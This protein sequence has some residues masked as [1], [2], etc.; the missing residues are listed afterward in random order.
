M[1]TATHDTYQLAGIDPRERGF[2]RPVDLMPEDRQYRARLRYEASHITTELAPS[3]D[4]ALQLLITVLQG[5][6]YRQLKT[7]ISFRQGAYLGSGE[8]WTE[9]PDPPPVQRGLLAAIRT[10][11]KRDTL[12]A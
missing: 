2:S 10:W 7:Q 5:Q 11:F 3:Q 12:S 9:Y 1:A 4:E 6:G 8:S